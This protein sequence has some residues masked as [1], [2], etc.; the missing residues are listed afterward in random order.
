VDSITLEKLEFDQIR[1]ILARYCRCA[2]GREL[3][4]RIGPSRRP[5]TA[6]HWL[7]E[8]NQ[9]VGALRD[10]RGHPLGN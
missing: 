10:F 5:E 9:M 1:K 7:D 2:L 3:A 4:M 8:T 6:Q